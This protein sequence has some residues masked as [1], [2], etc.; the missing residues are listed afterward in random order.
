MMDRRIFI[1]SLFLTG[2]AA[3]AGAALLPRNA[4]AAP[5]G[6]T[7]AEAEPLA[8]DLPA[9]GAQEAV[10]VV[11]RRPRRRVCV[12]RVGPRGVVRRVCRIE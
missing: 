12:T 11:R 2:G 6:R 10:I 5:R 1:R 9:K 7:L 8:A 4:Q 3:V